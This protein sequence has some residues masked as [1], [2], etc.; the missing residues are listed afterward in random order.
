[1]DAHNWLLGFHSWLF[2]QSSQALGFLS[3]IG[4]VAAAIRWKTAVRRDILLAFAIYLLGASLR[5]VVV[6]HYHSHW[7][8]LAYTF[9]GVSQLVQ[10]V[11]VTMFLRACFSGHCP[12]WVLW[13]LLGFVTL[14]VLVV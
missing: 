6:Y 3:L 12:T 13:T 14:I 2:Q 11:G 7:T 4:V 1:M 5:E 8:E 10:L 9:S